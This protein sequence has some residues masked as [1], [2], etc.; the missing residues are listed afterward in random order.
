ME[1]VA[2][3]DLLHRMAR[4]LRKDAIGLYLPNDFEL[5]KCSQVRIVWPVEAN[6]VFAQIPC[7]AIAKIMERYFYYPWIEEECIVRWMCSF[8]TTEQ[9]VKEF[10]GFVAEAVK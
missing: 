10:A 9:D 6:G 5:R 2:V 8:D 4:N 1:K 7:A 3:F